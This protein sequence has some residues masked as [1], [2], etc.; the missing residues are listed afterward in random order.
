MIDH[1]VCSQAEWLAGRTK[2]LQAEKELTRRSDELAHAWRQLPWVR[3]EKDYTYDTE[4]GP[5]SL[6]D[7]FGGR[8]QLLSTT[9]CSPA[10]P[11]AH[12]SPTASTPAPT[13]WRTTTS[14]WLRSA[15]LR[16]RTWR[17]S[18]D[19]SG[20]RARSTTNFVPVATN[21]ATPAATAPISTGRQLC[22]RNEGAAA[23]RSN[24]APMA[25]R[26]RR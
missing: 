9:S 19:G 11:A 13:T 8:S 21:T 12:R 20:G 1:R 2:L 22:R 5:A 16:S 7:L 15:V 4:S 26:P 24:R 18:G 23:P 14:R 3:V 25:R 10:V 6:T 17:R